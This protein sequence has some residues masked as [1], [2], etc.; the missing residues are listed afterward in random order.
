MTLPDRERIAEHGGDEIAERG[1]VGKP[2]LSPTEHGQEVVHG[3]ALAVSP[4]PGL[5]VARLRNLLVPHRDPPHVIATWIV[6]PVPVHLNHGTNRA[7]CSSPF[8]I[9][10]V[11]PVQKNSG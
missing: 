9:C 3:V 1:L 4:V 7:R 11:P 2:E 10:T 8:E 5:D 6:T